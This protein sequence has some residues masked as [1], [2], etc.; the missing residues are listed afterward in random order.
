MNYTTNMSFHSPANATTKT[1]SEGETVKNLTMSYPL[2]NLETNVAQTWSSLE[3]LSADFAS[4]WNQIEKLESIMTL[5]RQ[6]MTSFDEPTSL[7]ASSSKINFNNS[8][9]KS[10]DQ[11]SQIQCNIP[12]VGSDNSWSEFFS[13]PTTIENGSSIKL[14]DS[15]NSIDKNNLNKSDIPII[16]LQTYEND[17]D[18][19][20]EQ[21]IN[22]G[23]A[24]ETD[25]GRSN[26]DNNE[27]D[28]QTFSYK[29]ENEKV[30]NLMDYHYVPSSAGLPKSQ[31]WLG[32]DNSFKNDSHTD[33][34]HTYY[35]PQP[36]R[37][38][39]DPQ[40][41]RVGVSCP[42]LDSCTK[43]NISPTSSSSYLSK[44]TE[45]SSYSR[46]N[47]CSPIE[48]KYTNPFLCDH[49]LTE[50][51]PGRLINA[52]NFIIR[53]NND[54][55]EYDNVI[56]ALIQFHSRSPSPESPPPPA[57]QDCHSYSYYPEKMVYDFYK[58][59]LE[60]EAYPES[61][62]HLN[63]IEPIDDSDPE[64]II[65]K[66]DF[67]YENQFHR[68]NV[69]L[70]EYE[71]PDYYS[72]RL[73]D[74]AL[75]LID[76]LQENYQLRN[77]LA[78]AKYKSWT[79]IP[80]EQSESTIKPHYRSSL[81]KLDN[82][83]S[84]QQRPARHQRPG[85][86]SSRTF[87]G[88]RSRLYASSD[89][90]HKSLQQNTVDHMSSVY[91]LAGTDLYTSV[92]TSGLSCHETPKCE[93]PQFH[94]PDLIVGQQFY[95]QHKLDKNEMAKNFPTYSYKPD[96]APT[97][98]PPSPQCH[99][100]EVTPAVHKRSDSTA[101]LPNYNQHWPLANQRS[102]S[103][104]RP[105]FYG[106]NSQQKHPSEVKVKPLE[107]KKSRRSTLRSAFSTVGNSV[108][109]WIPN[110]HLTQRRHS[111]PSPS[112]LK[113]ESG[114]SQKKKNPII[115]MMAGMFH[116]S[117]KTG[118][119]SSDSDSDVNWTNTCEE[120]E[121]VFIESQL[122]SQ[123]PDLTKG[124]K[125]M[126]AYT[127]IK[128]PSVILEHKL[129]TPAEPV[130]NLKFE[131][132]DIDYQ[133]AE[134][135]TLAEPVVPE[136][137]PKPYLTNPTISIETFDESEIC[138][139]DDEPYGLKPKVEVTAT[140]RRCALPKQFS[141]DVSQNMQNDDYR[142]D[143]SNHSWCSTMSKTSSRRQSTEESIDTEDEWYMYEFRKL[144]NLER[145]TETEKQT[146]D[147]ESSKNTS[148]IEEY[149]TG[150]DLKGTELIS[151]IK[152]TEEE[153]VEQ[154]LKDT[155]SITEIVE[156]VSGS[157]DKTSGSNSPMAVEEVSRYKQSTFQISADEEKSQYELDD[158]DKYASVETRTE[159]ILE[160]LPK[161]KDELPREDEEQQIQEE[162]CKVDEDE[163]KMPGTPS[164][165][166]FR[167]NK[168]ESGESPHTSR[169]EISKDGMLG[170]KWKL[171]KALKERKA[172][173]KSK[174]TES[175]PPVVS[176]NI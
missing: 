52:S 136:T 154:K 79:N 74:D 13:I 42:R 103:P 71:R 50:E 173:E 130:T 24:T 43:I 65:S 127:P 107:V 77:M 25:L 75:D 33:S 10:T 126:N 47:F 9:F 73:T 39:T 96:D 174:E 121:D 37:K 89:Q 84:C 93:R 69:P 109:Q 70:D 157:S 32:L 167:Y 141:L 5:Q 80:Q 35:S 66:I 72:S 135:P 104:V 61:M 23:S 111:F 82:Q 63:P 152:M 100:L 64:D 83:Y 14:S 140:P 45:Y 131:D 68:P 110:F 44:G 142:D 106:S 116:K 57:P 67:L 6:I 56:N 59:E 120:T 22:F 30:T 163:E 128:R 98:K 158:Y 125:N 97:V 8:G 26:K 175:P 54:I 88:S 143:K 146:N 81:M 86:G 159:K 46:S 108:S 41:S 118:F 117:H 27:F 48:S 20:Y 18:Y 17:S 85:E 91:S 55:N 137:Q 51:D 160:E 87:R 2:E 31:S 90:F 76:R 40:S 134:T 95:G 12:S 124:M 153:E 38:L 105:L 19:M 62:S 147:T 170:S 28:D 34:L 164:L 171:L 156:Q 29:K 92:Y 16:K 102:S 133:M 138:E 58:D 101:M 123:Y 112:H 148:M 129:S 166:R 36:T 21:N 7:S 1:E 122:T 11:S 139:I 162:L 168:S 113:K 78:S 60:Y 150:D 15:Y 169:E 119:T 149:A 165:P 115:S 4:M 151:C 132:K 114:L 145:Q 161:Q 99:P 176:F 144:E 172:E 155:L 3:I 53:P 49:K 94:T